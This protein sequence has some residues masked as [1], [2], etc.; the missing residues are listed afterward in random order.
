MSVV[1]APFQEDQVNSINACQK[2]GYFHPLT[3][4]NNSNHPPLVATEEGLI[5][6]KCNYQQIWVFEWIANWEWSK[7]K[8]VKK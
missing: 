2:S 8:Y 3:C 6:L 4:G 1:Y 7:K 5:C